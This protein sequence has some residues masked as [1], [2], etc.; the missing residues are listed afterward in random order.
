MPRERG[1]VSVAE[2]IASA[3]SVGLTCGAIDPRIAATRRVLPALFGAADGPLPA[4]GQR[5]SE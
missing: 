1:A 3:A 4:G 5:T 2:T